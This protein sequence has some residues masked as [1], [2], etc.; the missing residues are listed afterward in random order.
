MKKR[1]LFVLA[2]L[3]LGTLLTA[4]TLLFNQKSS[5]E[6]CGGFGL[7]QVK[8]GLPLP[9]ILVRP[10]VSLC[11]SVEPI[12]IL[13]EGNAYHEQYPLNIV[14][15]VIFWS[16]ISALAVVSFRKTHESK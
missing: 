11:N 15:D 9:V 4:A 6:G 14:V 10:S 2:I 13:W 7:H 8:K 1:I 5:F 12:S 16:G 3:A